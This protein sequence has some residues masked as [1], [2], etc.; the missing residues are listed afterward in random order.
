MKRL[1]KVAVGIVVAA[2]L[3]GGGA[4]VYA[5]RSL[6]QLSGTVT[7]AG[8]SAPVEIVRD[9]NAIPHILATNRTDAL[10]GLGYV[11]AQDRLWQMEMSRRAAQ[12]R[13]SEVVGS[14]TVST[15]RYLRTVGLARAAKTAW[16]AL[17]ADARTAVGAYVA[18]VNAFIDTHGRSELS[19]EFTLLAIAPERWTGPDVIAVGKLLA[20]DMNSTYLDELMRSEFIA[21]VGA[22][23]AAQLMPAY[24]DDAPTTIAGAP[25]VAKPAQPSGHPELGFVAPA[26]RSLDAHV[27]ELRG[28]E[29]GAARAIGSNNWVVD[30]TRTTTGKPL[31]ASDPHLEAVLPAFWYLA[32]IKGGELDV[33]G[34][35]LPGI[36]AV[37]IGRNRSIS[38]GVTNAQADDQDLFRERLD[39][40]GTHAEFEGVMEPIQIFTETIKVRFGAD[41]QHRVRVTRNGPILSDAINPEDLEREEN[42]RPAPLEPLSLRWPAL[43]REDGTLGSFLKL[44][45]ASDWPGFQQALRSYVAPAQNFIYADVA[46]NIGYLMPGLHPLRAANGDGALPREGWT[47]KDQWTGWIPFEGLPQSYNPPEHFIAT[48][49]NRP[50]PSSYR[51]FLGDVWEAPYRVQRIIEMLKT[52]RKLGP[53][54]F[55]KMQGDTVSLFARDLVP[56]LLALTTAKTPQQ[57]QALELLRGWDFDTRADSAA[58]AIFEAWFQQLVDA[59]AGD[60]LGPRLL[61]DYDGNF[62]VVSL[63]LSR[64]LSTRDDPWCDD[65]RT[66]ASEDCTSVA[67]GALTRALAKLEAKMGSKLA[68]WQ[69]GTVH[70]LVLDHVPF[71]EVPVLDGIY[72]RPIHNGGDWSTVNLGTFHMQR[73]FRQR[74]IPSYRQVADLSSSSGGSFIVAGGQSGHV[75]SPHYDDGLATWQAHGYLPMQMDRA[76]VEQGR[77]D[78]LR[79]QP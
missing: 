5:R 32:Q 79:L 19:T 3:F 23:R 50:V 63:F 48:A 1:L 27:R 24:P 30:G 17:D 14:P 38:W 37:L 52:D 70:R 28:G 75:L 56:K 33:I 61:D 49:N 13:L 73:S 6:P 8:L 40:D 29:D 41:V 77:V 54:D 12:G 60:E 21:K 59:V 39:A 35:T 10:F 44:N 20:W 9:A 51:Y 74:I 72:S 43:N 46:G 76:Q 31:L 62:Q 16:E 67:S 7:V 64:T 34:S 4:Y 71:G 22:A 47:Q 58:A 25:A 65:V 57:T 36:P 53:K 68:T 55:E 18:G 45:L 15:D 2:L 26:L 69:W 78:T 11:H 66:A 42:R